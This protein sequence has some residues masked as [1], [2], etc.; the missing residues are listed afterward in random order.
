MRKPQIY[1]PAFAILFIFILFSP[2]NL[3]SQEA[4]KQGTWN[5]T[6]K[7]RHQYTLNGTWQIIDEENKTV[8]E[9]QVPGI[10][11]ARGKIRLRYAFKLPDSLYNRTLLLHALGINRSCKIL[12]N[13]TFIAGHNNG[14]TSFDALLKPSNLRRGEENIIQIEINTESEGPNDMPFRHEPPGWVRE[15]GILRDIYL[16]A[17]PAISIDDAYFSP[18]FTNSYRDATIKTEATIRAFRDTPD[19]LKNVDTFSLYAQILKTG[20]NKVLGKSNTRFF[21]FSGLNNKHVDSLTINL[22]NCDLWEPLTPNLYTIR[23][24]LFA[25][26]T[27]IDQAEYAIGLNEIKVDKWHILLNGKQFFAKGISWV[28]NLAGLSGDALQE[29]I[30][31]TIAQIKSLGANVVRV[32]GHATHPDFIKA[33]SRAGLFVLQE[34]PLYQANIKQLA[35]PATAQKALTILEETIIRDRNQP[36]MFGWGL[37]T[38]LQDFSGDP[39]SIISQLAFRARSLDSRLIYMVSRAQGQPE[40]AKVVDFVLLD[41]FNV[42]GINSND[43]WFT[44]Q[45]V[46][47][48]IGYPAAYA[49]LPRNESHP[50][51][52]RI[53]GEEIQ[54]NRLEK[55]LRYFNENWPGYSGSFVHSLAD[56][57][58]DQPLLITG[59][60]R[61]MNLYPFG[62]TRKDGS[63]RIGYRMVAAHFHGGRKPPVSTPIIEEVQPTLFPILGFSTLLVFLFFL[64]RDKK[65]RAQIRRAF[66]HPHGFYTDLRDNRKIPLFL[67]T[68]L[69][70]LE[71]IVLALLLESVF[72][73]FRKNLLFDEMLNLLLPSTLLKTQFIQLVWH[74]TGMILAIILLY[75]AAQILLAMFM[76]ILSLLIGHSIPL[77]QFIT[78]VFWAA[79]CY[80]PLLLLAPILYK[81][82]LIGESTEYLI[83]LPAAFFV[84]HIFRLQ[85]GLRVLYF[86]SSIKSAIVVTIIF[87][88]IA[89]SIIFYYQQYHAIFDYYGYYEALLSRR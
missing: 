23:L 64:N 61:D 36:S 43:A 53:E 70:L 87:A 60:D 86:A 7:F 31:K 38:N 83:I 51:Q 19:S 35:S 63:E 82:L 62:L 21:K 71:G 78:F 88:T 32:F 47:P 25:G 6:T 59:A 29:R 68:L 69:G 10:I 30:D 40:A 22:K 74:P 42:A 80:F 48:L 3:L 12:I 79:V 45:P 1:F 66:I 5:R 58:G 2:L 41:R 15:H 52:Q 49:D 50:E 37:G 20:T 76:K 34:I 81:L 89:G 65:L 73:I 55:M 26:K 54:A 84:W 8:D 28:D 77:L 57:H 67:T 11:P 14:Y 17:R 18:E 4:I 24:S 56:W 16:E 33:C 44:R 27:R 75:F 72:F 46:L 39:L 9:I 13:D 85:R